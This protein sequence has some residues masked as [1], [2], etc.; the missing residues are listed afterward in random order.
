MPLDFIKENKD[1]FIAIA[2]WF[3]GFFT[4]IANKI[5]KWEVK[6]IG[7]IFFH[8]SSAWF[9]GW[10]SY[11]ICNYYGIT[12]PAIWIIT[13]IATYSSSK[14]IDAIDM[15]KAK[16]ISNLIIEFITFKLWGKK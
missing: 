16:T 2:S 4:L 11:L 14:I 13:G 7:L 3:W 12:W 8:I 15:I 1:W 5:I 10:I 6:S 9:I